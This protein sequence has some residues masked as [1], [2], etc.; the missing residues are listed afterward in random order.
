MMSTMMMSILQYVAARNEVIDGQRS[1]ATQRRCVL[2]S[3]YEYDT[4]I[5][6]RR[7]PFANKVSIPAEYAKMRSIVRTNTSRAREL[8]PRAI[9][10]TFPNDKFTFPFVYF[11]YFRCRSFRWKAR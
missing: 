8:E 2:A 6:Y 1:R 9:L 5:S 3:I 11:R 10:L 7:C 4:L